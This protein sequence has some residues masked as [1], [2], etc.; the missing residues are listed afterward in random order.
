MIKKLCFM[1]KESHGIDRPQWTNSWSLRRLTRMQRLSW[2]TQ[3]SVS[4]KN[5]ERMDDFVEFV[6]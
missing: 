6:V 4:A 5:F 2:V 3:K 1:A